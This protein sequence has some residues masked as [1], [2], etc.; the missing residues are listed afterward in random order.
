MEN[1]KT[2]VMIL[3][4]M[5][6][7]FAIALPKQYGKIID[8]LLG[9]SVYVIL[10]SIGFGLAAVRNLWAQ[11]SSVFVYV[12]VLFVLLMVCNI[13]FLRAFDYFFPQHTVLHGKTK[14]KKINFLDNLKQPA[15]VLLGLFLGKI[16]PEQYWLPEKTGTY[17]LMLL[18]FLV[19]LQLRSNDVPL[20][21]ILLNKRGLQVSV[22]FTLSCFLAGILFAAIFDDVSLS[23]G[24]ALSSGYGWYSLSG[25]V[26]TQA[27]GATWGSVAL[28]NDLLREFFALMF[29][30]FLM[31]SSPSAA[32]GVGGAT[33]L[34]FS[35]PVIQSSGG[36][37]A[38]SLAISYGFVVNITS[39]FLM[40][41]FSSF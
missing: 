37:S 17:V 41:I 6:I 16:L 15:I 24:L 34:D 4:P 13:I 29:I 30:P 39:P 18:I 20:K 11:L 36:L 23:K 27:Y 26:M 22:V 25:I 5:F 3:M 9:W 7:G 14:H 19:G 8:R 40:V 31:R 33:S 32:V 35:L 1:I 2:I 38:V 10:L 28:L 12:L 21:H